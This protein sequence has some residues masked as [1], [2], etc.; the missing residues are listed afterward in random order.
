MTQPAPIRIFIPDSGPLIALAVADELG[1][2]LKVA[3]DV[4]LLITDHVEWKVTRRDD[5]P[6]APKIA[7]FF[8]A[9]ADRVE[10][11]ETSIGKMARAGLEAAA[12]NGE[13]IKRMKDLG[14]LSIASAMIQ[15]RQL[16]PGDATLV[17]IEVEWFGR[18]ASRQGQ[19]AS[20]VHLCVAPGPRGDRRDS[21]RRRHST[22][23]LARQAE[24]QGR[25]HRGLPRV[26]DRTRHR[27]AVQ[28]PG[29]LTPSGPRAFAKHEH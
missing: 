12:L 20:A 9:N 7:A 1:L 2:L 23:D 11:V 18:H 8:R 4:R 21:V 26:E 13:E 25:I 10:V 6:D 28:V 16:N 29:I 22:E 19:C 3:G 15:M 24:L 17:L 27:V 14:E 5:L